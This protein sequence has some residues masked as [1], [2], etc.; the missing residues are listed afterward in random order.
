MQRRYA[1]PVEFQ[2]ARTKPPQSALVLKQAGREVDERI[3]PI[4]SARFTRASRSDRPEIAR[5]SPRGPVVNRTTNDPRSSFHRARS[6]LRV[7]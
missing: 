4:R 7:A 6:A 3:G 1:R 2:C 5:L